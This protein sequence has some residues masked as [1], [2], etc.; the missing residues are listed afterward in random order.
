MMLTEFHTGH[1]SLMVQDDLLQFCQ[2]GS[3]EKPDATL[4]EGRRAYDHETQPFE[5]KD[6]EL[7]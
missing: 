3:G 4:M 5:K 7:P 1:T 6:T 2:V